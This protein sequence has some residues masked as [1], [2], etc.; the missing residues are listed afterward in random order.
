M[1]RIINLTNEYGHS[2]IS[3]TWTPSASRI[4]INGWYDSCVGIQGE[5]M[6]LKEFFERLGIKK[7]DIDKAMRQREAADEDRI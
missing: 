5:S 3:V 4:D 1:P 2:G 7:T 6:T